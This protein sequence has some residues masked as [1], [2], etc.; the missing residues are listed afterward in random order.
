MERVEERVEAV[1]GEGGTEG[2]FV[3]RMEK[4]AASKKVM[5]EERE[6]RRRRCRW[7][8]ER[9]RGRVRREWRK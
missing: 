9:K 3:Q 6:K 8:R 4:E 2:T 7:R 5:A 1:K